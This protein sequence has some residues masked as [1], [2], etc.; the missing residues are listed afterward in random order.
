MDK[1][2]AV[3]NREIYLDYTFIDNSQISKEDNS[4]KEVAQEVKKI[5]LPQVELPRENLNESAAFIIIPDTSFSTQQSLAIKPRDS[6][7]ALD[8]LL[9]IDPNLL[10]LRT[11]FMG[12]VI[13]D[14]PQDTINKWRPITPVG[15]Q[16]YMEMLKYSDGFKNAQMQDEYNT[17]GVK[18]PLDAIFDL[19]K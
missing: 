11:V 3:M 7:T 6:L 16:E 13:N 14:T 5:P 4:S 12:R 1:Q 8:S 19:F 18:I 15:I 10:V 17:G 2:P 9:F